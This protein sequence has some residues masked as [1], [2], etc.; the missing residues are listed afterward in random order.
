VADRAA[1]LMQTV[2]LRGAGLDND[3]SNTKIGAMSRTLLPA[4]EG[5]TFWGIAG[6]MFFFGIGA[7]LSSQTTVIPSFL[8]TLTSSAPLIGGWILAAS[9]SYNLLFAAA[10]AGPLGGLL[11]LR[12][13]PEP[14][15]AA[16]VKG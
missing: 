6:D 7:S 5:R 16:T 12:T 4:G 15:R 11:L 14:R 10:A 8:A 9:G 3:E 1:F 13:L 2:Y